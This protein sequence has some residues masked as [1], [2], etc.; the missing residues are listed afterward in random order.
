MRI[1]GWLWQA[2]RRASGYFSVGSI[3]TVNPF[4]VNW[5]L[6]SSARSW[7]VTSS[8]A[9]PVLSA[10]SVRVLAACSL[11]CVSSTIVFTTCRCVFTS[12]LCSS[13]FQGG[14]I[15]GGVFCGA[16]L[17]FFFDL[18][19]APPVGVCGTDFSFSLIAASGGNSSNHYRHY[20]PPDEKPATTDLP[21]PPSGMPAAR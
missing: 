20:S 19:A 2:L 9:T 6:Y 18:V 13:T 17:D 10:S 15:L 3:V 21:R 12:S 5:S 1:Y 7:W 4:E 11:R 14:S 8:S 16:G